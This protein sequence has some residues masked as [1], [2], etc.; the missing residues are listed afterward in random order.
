MEISEKVMRD[1]RKRFEVEGNKKE[2]EIIEY[3]KKELENIYRKKH[4][5]MSAFEV[6]IR[7]LTERMNNRIAMLTRMVREES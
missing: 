7:A 5:T 3:W 1:L 2:L 6:D 4:Q